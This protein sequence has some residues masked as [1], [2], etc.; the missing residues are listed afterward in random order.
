MLSKLSPK[1]AAIEKDLKDHQLELQTAP[2]GLKAGIAR[3]I[4][5]LRAQLAACKKKHPK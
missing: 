4:K 5:Q 1:C 3:Q 2:P